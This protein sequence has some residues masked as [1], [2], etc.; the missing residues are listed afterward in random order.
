M[1]LVPI[2]SVA[3]AEEFLSS[4]KQMNW[5]IIGTQS[6][7][8]SDDTIP[9]IPVNELQSEKPSLVIFGRTILILEIFTLNIF[10]LTGNEGVGIPKNVMALCN[11]STYIQSRT[12]NSMIVD[13]LN[14]SSAAAIILHSIFW[15]K[16]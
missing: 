8:V 13:S 16:N 9:C 12:N 10:L 4:I 3:N 11:H 2:Y 7:P 14:V 15:G 5:N 1:E 6:K